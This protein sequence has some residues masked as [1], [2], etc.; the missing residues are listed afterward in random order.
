MT[1]RGPHIVLGRL[2]QKESAQVSPLRPAPMTM[3]SRSDMALHGVIE[4]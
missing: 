4:H 2:L 1:N 3:A